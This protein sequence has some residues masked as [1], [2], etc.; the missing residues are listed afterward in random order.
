MAKVKLKYVEAITEQTGAMARE[1]ERT[2]D[3]LLI[4]T[5]KGI[6]AEATN[7]RV[8]LSLIQKM[9]KNLRGIILAAREDIIK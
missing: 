2:T 6:K 8:S 5:K 1:M 7:A 9:A 4:F 3:S